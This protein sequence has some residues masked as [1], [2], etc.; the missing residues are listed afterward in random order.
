MTGA[1]SADGH[2]VLFWKWLESVAQL[3]EHRPFKALVLGSSPSALTIPLLPSYSLSGY[4]LFV[5]RRA[6]IAFRKS[7]EHRRGLPS[8]H[9]RASPL[10]PSPCRGASKTAIHLCKSSPQNPAPSC[11]EANPCARLL[12]CVHRSYPAQ[13]DP[14]PDQATSGRK[15]ASAKSHLQGSLAKSQAATRRHVPPIDSP[16]TA[17]CV[18]GTLANG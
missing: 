12:Q 17:R 1:P 9:R 7:P 5:F 4:L 8:P 16:C 2:H 13:P 6:A 15:N 11:S 18:W 3:V 10:N 14:S